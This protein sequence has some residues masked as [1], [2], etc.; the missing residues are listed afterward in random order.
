MP[1][2]KVC[3]TFEF[4]GPSH[5]RTVRYLTFIAQSHLP[6]CLPLYFLSTPLPLPHCGSTNAYTVA[7]AQTFVT[8]NEQEM[9]SYRNCEKSIP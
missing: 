2:L 5:D 4:F 9:N 6:H 7:K 8:R 1:L 3:F